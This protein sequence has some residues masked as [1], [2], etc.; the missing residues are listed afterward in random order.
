MMSRPC[1]AGSLRR[2]QPRPLRSMSCASCSRLDMLSSRSAHPGR[3]LG[4]VVGEPRTQRAALLRAD[5]NQRS[6]AGGELTLVALVAS[7]E[8]VFMQA[9][10]KRGLHTQQMQD[11]AWLEL[12]VRKARNPALLEQQAASLDEA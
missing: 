12:V 3:D 9:T 4:Q 11:Q 2:S 6:R 1:Q 10:R 5:P 7:Q 8:V